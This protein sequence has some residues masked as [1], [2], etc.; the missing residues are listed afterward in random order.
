MIKKENLKLMEQITKIEKNNTE[1]QERLKFL[2]N[3]QKNLSQMLPYL[4]KIKAEQESLKTLTVSDD[5]PLSKLKD[6]SLPENVQIRFSHKKMTKIAK[7]S[8]KRKYL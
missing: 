5:M 8:K 7:M 1:L 3:E 4:K 6:V 2:R